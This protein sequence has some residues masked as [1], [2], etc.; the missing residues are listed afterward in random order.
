MGEAA[1][2]LILCAGATRRDG[3]TTLDASPLHGPDICA[4]VPPLPTEVKRHKWEAVELIHGISSFYPWE[5]D[6]LLA[7]LRDVM[8]PD[9]VLI[10][11]QPDI[12]K[13]MASGVVRWVF[14]DPSHGHAGYMNH[15]GYTPGT[16]TERLLAAGFT[17]LKVLPAQHH[18]PPRDFRIEAQP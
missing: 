12:S 8:E 6:Q 11:E 9:G 14:G 17:R 1:V 13:A 7:E 3:W 15:W 16:L 2:K 10:L 18:Y 5:A 4:T